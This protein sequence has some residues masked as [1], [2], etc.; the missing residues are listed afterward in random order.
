VPQTYRVDQAATFTRCVLVEIAPKL[1]FG[2]KTDEQDV[3]GDKVPR[4]N[5]EVMAGF[6]AFGRSVNELIRVGFDA[7][8]EPQIE[9]FTPVEL[10]DFEI[11]F[12]P[13]E[14]ENKKTGVTEMTGVT[15]W[16]RCSEIRPISATGSGRRSHL[17]TAEAASG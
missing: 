2:T 12:M 3:N 13:K 6:R 11:G 7:E 9:P 15:V 1:V 10:V 8:R 14:R 17:A 5:A 16:C 4:W